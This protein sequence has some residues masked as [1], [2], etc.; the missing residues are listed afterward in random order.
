MAKELVKQGYAMWEKNAKDEQQQIVG[1]QMK[2]PQTASSE[3][4]SPGMNS[5]TVAGAAG[6]ENHKNSMASEDSSKIKS[7]ESG[8]CEDKRLVLSGDV[9]PPAEFFNESDSEDGLEMG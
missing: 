8:V 7:E 9:R 2:Q 1:K 4:V 6:K 3:N 5:N